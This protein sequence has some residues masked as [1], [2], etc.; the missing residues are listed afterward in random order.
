[1]GERVGD[2]GRPELPHQR[3]RDRRRSPR[4]VAELVSGEQAAFGALREDTAEV[5]QRLLDAAATAPARD[6]L[7]DMVDGGD[8]RGRPLSGHESEPRIRRPGC[9]PRCRPSAPSAASPRDSSTAINAGTRSGNSRATHP[10]TRASADEVLARRLEPDVTAIGGHPRDGGDAP[11]L[12]RL[13]QLRTATPQ[14]TSR[15]ESIHAS[16]RSNRPGQNRLA[17]RAAYRP[18]RA[19]RRRRWLTSARSGSVGEDVELARTADRTAGADEV[20]PSTVG[21]AW[22]WGRAAMS[23]PTSSSAEPGSRGCWLGH[24]RRQGARLVDEDPAVV[25]EGDVVRLGRA[26]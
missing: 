22:R 14:D 24:E 16:T 1:M 20:D 12:H 7:V 23:A 19:R 5:G 17:E 8:L 15:T 18:D 2:P 4:I 26:G 6:E 3:L 10:W 21:G 9:R 13:D 11:Q 25:Q